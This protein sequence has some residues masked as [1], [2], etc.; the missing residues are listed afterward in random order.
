MSSDKNWSVYLLK[1]S[2]NSLYCGV[3]TDLQ[4]RLIKHNDGT[5]SKYTRSKRPVKLAAIK[6]ELTKQQA[7]QLEYQVKKRPKNKK[8]NF[9]HDWNPEN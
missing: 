6:K 5:A 2:D 4:N 9:L 7:Y 1:C 8:I 3:T